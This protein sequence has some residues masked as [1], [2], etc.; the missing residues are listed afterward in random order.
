M[1]TTTQIQKP[2]EADSMPLSELPAPTKPAPIGE[3]P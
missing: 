3:L 1:D 2:K